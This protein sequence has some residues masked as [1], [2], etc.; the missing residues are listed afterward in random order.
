MH[1]YHMC[2]FPQIWKY[3]SPRSTGKICVFMSDKESWY[4]K[5]WQVS[6]NLRLLQRWFRDWISEA[7]NG[8]KIISPLSNSLSYKRN[9]L[10][11]NAQLEKSI[12]PLKQNFWF[13]SIAFLNSIPLIFPGNLTKLQPVANQ[14]PHGLDQEKVFQTSEFCPKSRHCFHTSL[15]CNPS[16]TKN[17]TEVAWIHSLKQRIIPIFFSN[18]HFP[19]FHKFTDPSV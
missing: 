2:S 3:L 15:M 8:L 1:W 6:D 4:V 17:T 18:R 10:F 5:F 7:L 16:L 12:F 11:L 13:S 19:S 14:S 9:V